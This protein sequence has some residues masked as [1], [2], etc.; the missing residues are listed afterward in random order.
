M[1]PTRT[2]LLS[3][4]K[5][6]CDAFSQKKDVPPIL[7]LFSTT[8]QVSALEHGEPSL[9]PFLGRPFV[10]TANV[11]KYFEIIGSLLSYDDVK[12]SEF[13]V[14]TET[15]RVAL[16]GQGKFTWLSTGESWD[17]TF[18]YMLDFDDELKVT[19]YQVWADSG[20]AYLARVGK[21]DEVRKVH[22]IV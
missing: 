21:L 14:D 13:V 17:E 8:H 1:S 7:A 10:G 11:Q 15:S 3:V 22:E 12:F 4:A 18:A 20:A 2:N 5:T 6:F 16:K 9:A 19:D